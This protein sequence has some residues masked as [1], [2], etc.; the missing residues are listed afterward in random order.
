MN[1]V[2]LCSRVHGCQLVLWIRRNHC[3]ALDLYFWVWDIEIQ[4]AW[5]EVRVPNSLVII[6]SIGVYGCLAIKAEFGTKTYRTY[7]GDHQSILSTEFNEVAFFWGVNF[8]WI[9]THMEMVAFSYT[10]FWSKMQQFFDSDDLYIVESPER[11]RTT[12][13]NKCNRNA[14]FKRPNRPHNR[15]CFCSNI[16]I[17]LL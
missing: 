14:R 15:S 17:I 11:N 16:W 6:K 8:V 5:I 2:C 10:I 4:Q 7:W 9:V 13:F 1:R 3:G 12:V